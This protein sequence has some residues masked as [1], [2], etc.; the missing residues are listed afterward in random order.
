MRLIKVIDIIIILLIG[1]V[2]YPIVIYVVE[3]YLIFGSLPLLPYHYYIQVWLCSP[4]LILFGL[5]EV[6]EF[7]RKIFGMSIV[8][9]GI[10]WF[11]I[12]L[13]EIYG[14]SYL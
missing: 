11:L 7:K 2:L 6:F 8:I 3:N 14:K 13:F 9:I 4:L 1:I 5:L 10:T 12:I